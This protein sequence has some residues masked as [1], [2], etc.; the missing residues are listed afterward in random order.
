MVRV[1]ERSFQKLS[2]RSSSS[3]ITR[4]NIINELEATVEKTYE[5]L[6]G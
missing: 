4:L 3:R 1:Y 6:Q 2:L 5:V